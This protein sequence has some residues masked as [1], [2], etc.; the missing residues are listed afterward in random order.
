MEK[1]KVYFGE[2][3]LTSTSANYIANKAKEMVL[4]LEV[5]LNNVNFLNVYMSLLDGDQSTKKIMHK[6]VT[7]DD[8]KLF[9]ESLNMIAGMKSLQ[10]WLREAIK[11]KERLITEARC[12]KPEDWAKTVNVEWPVHPTFKEWTL[13]DYLET[14]SVHDKNKYLELETVCSVYGKFI[15]KNGAFHEARKRLSNKITNP[16]E[17]I[18][19]GHNTVIK[20]YEPGVNMEVVEQTYFNLTEIHRKAQAQLNKMK[21]EADLW[22]QQKQNSQTSEYK[23]QCD[24]YNRKYDELNVLYKQYVNDE[25]A[26]AV[27][28]KIV[29]PNSLK[30]IYEQVNKL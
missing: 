25:I 16:T 20:E 1:D 28:L 2:A 3:G 13:D 14:L 19:E 23:N 27:A 8:I 6:S 30:D 24:E 12:I 17:I 26:R 18:G 9:E 4:Q 21:H 22:V 7:N 29:I 15:H 11:A 10:A 5:A